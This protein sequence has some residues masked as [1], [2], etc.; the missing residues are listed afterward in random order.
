MI[1]LYRVYPG[2]GK[3]GNERLWAWGVVLLFGCMTGLNFNIKSPIAKL[4]A[5]TI[6]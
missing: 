1:I 5:Q 4:D 2:A 6:I 3:R